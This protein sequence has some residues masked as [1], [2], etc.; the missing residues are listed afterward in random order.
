[1]YGK[2]EKQW[3]QPSWD[4]PRILLVRYSFSNAEVLCL[5]LHVIVVKVERHLL[6]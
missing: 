4:R 5:L 2:L 6:L 3:L 1:V